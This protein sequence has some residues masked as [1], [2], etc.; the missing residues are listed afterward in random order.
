MKLKPCPFCGGEAE[1]IQEDIA[2]L[3]AVNCKECKC[4]TPFQ[5]NF[6]EGS[7][8]KAL[9]VWNRREPIDKIVKQ[10][11][12]LQE[13][14]PYKVVGDY[15]TYSQYNQAW[16]SCSDQAIEIVKKGGGID[17]G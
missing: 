8:K 4:R 16:E 14:H 15:D 13:R 6:G 9:K 2:G 17:E 3:Y 5:F 12:E 11:E 1:F 7:E 10:L